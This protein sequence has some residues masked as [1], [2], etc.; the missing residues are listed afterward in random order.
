M[1]KALK[2]EVQEEISAYITSKETQKQQELH[3]QGIKYFNTTALIACLGSLIV[4]LVL[5]MSFPILSNYLLIS[6]PLFLLGSGMSYFLI[7][8]EMKLS[9]KHLLLLVP[10]L[11]YGAWFTFS[12]VIFFLF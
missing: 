5:G 12:I 2:L 10:L 8:S 9:I 6:S 11:F 4:A 3:T 7:K 1:N